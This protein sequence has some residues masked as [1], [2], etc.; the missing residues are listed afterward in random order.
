MGNISQSGKR[1]ALKEFDVYFNHEQKQN[2]MKHKT[3]MRELIDT[4]QQLGIDFP[5][6]VEVFIMKE[7]NQIEESFMDGHRAS[8]K[9]NRKLLSINYYKDEYE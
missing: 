1:R 3:A 9:T 5:F 8:D 2:K 4:F 7:K 6:N